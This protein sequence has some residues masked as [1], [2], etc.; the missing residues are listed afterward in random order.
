MPCP[1]LNN[2]ELSVDEFTYI[3]ECLKNYKECYTVVKEFPDVRMEHPRKW[4]SEK[5]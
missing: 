5:R 3:N 2:C 1:N 4:K